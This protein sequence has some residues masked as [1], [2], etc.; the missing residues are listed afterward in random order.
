MFGF[1]DNVIVDFS[2]LSPESADALKRAFNDC[3]IKRE[4]AQKL[5]RLKVNTVV[6]IPCEKAAGLYA[7]FL[8]TTGSRVSAEEH[9]KDLMQSKELTITSV[10]KL[11]YKG[12]ELLCYTLTNEDYLMFV[13][14]EEYVREKKSA[15]EDSLL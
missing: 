5:A 7:L 15:G 13:V 11:S 14:P 3:E 2:G 8:E 1:D 9:Y 12:A 4:Q 6:E 10:E